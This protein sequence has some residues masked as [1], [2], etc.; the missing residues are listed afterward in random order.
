MEGFALA[1]QSPDAISA[2]WAS[3][4]PAISHGRIKPLGARAFA[5]EHA[6]EALRYLIEERP[7]GRVVLTV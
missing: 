7:F 2:A 6:P 4:V 5:L 1:A 3:I